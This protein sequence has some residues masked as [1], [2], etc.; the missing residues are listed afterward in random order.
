MQLSVALPRWVPSRRRAMGFTL[1][2][3]ASVAAGLLT[4]CPALAGNAYMPKGFEG[5]SFGMSE[6]ELHAVRPNAK[7]WRDFL[8]SRDRWKVP[9][10]PPIEIWFEEARDT[11]E[12]IDAVQY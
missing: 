2:V 3:T 12:L 10:P 1:A 6:A 11:S 9:D 5:V 4:R 7:P 8:P